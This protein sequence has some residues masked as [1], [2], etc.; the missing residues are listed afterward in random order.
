[1]ILKSFRNSKINQHIKI[2]IKIK[3]TNYKKL[4]KK[5]G[6]ILQKKKIINS[7][8]LIVMICVMKKANYLK[9]KKCY[10]VMIKEVLVCRYYQN[11]TKLFMNKKFLTIL[12]QYR[13]VY[14]HTNQKM[15][16]YINSM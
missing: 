10:Q 16:I 7:Y 8:I 5:K 2:L 1:M 13:L 14:S 4:L 12:N 11:N 6:H 9:N 3:K 15:K